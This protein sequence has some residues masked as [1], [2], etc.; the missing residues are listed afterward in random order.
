MLEEELRI[1]TLRNK[2][3][4]GPNNVEEEIDLKRQRKKTIDNIE[5]LKEEVKEWEFKRVRVLQDLS[6]EKNDE[7]VE[8]AKIELKLQRLGTSK[9][10]ISF[11]KKSII[12]KKYLHFFLLTK[13]KSV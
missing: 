5:E 10:S 3:H 2:Y 9:K 13:N 8:I 12:P 7:I 4:G 11:F 6:F 1:M